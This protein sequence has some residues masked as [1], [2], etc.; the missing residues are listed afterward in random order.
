MSASPPT[1]PAE[2]V[3]ARARRWLDTYGLPS[4]RDEAWR[5]APVRDIASRLAG[6][7]AAPAAAVDP[8]TVV[9]LAGR[10]GPTG[11]V[12]VNGALDRTLSDLTRL[13][14]G[15]RLTTVGPD[16][17]DSTALGDPTDGFDAL[18]LASAP[19]IVYLTVDDGLESTD[20]VHVV[21]VSVPS[22]PGIL[23]NPRVVVDV[24]SDARFELV[25]SYV[26]V[27]GGA[28]TNAATEL[29]L[30]VGAEVTGTRVQ[31]EAPD[32]V[33]V[34]RLDVTQQKGSRL[35]LGAFSRG[36][37]VGRFWANALLRGDDAVVDLHGLS[38]PMP[39]HRHDTMVSVHHAGDRGASDQQFRNVVGARAR[40]SFSGHVVIRPGV[41]GSDAHQ[42]SDSLLLSPDARADSRP[43]LEI[44]AD[45]VRCD[46][47]STTGR[48]DDDAL[49]YLRSRGIPEPVARR[50]LVEAF[51]GALTE[52][53]RPVSLRRAIDRWLDPEATA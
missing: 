43:W 3:A 52:R 34:G 29:R 14:A 21:H 19:E 45:D 40:S 35:T 12:L 6:A 20:P 7:E 22:S 13:H 53:L 49:F 25:E 18:S 33:H 42:R 2:L 30:G 48:L 32:A 46:H 9:E 10:H 8:A 50:M 44:F 51:A 24:G 31:V 41:V 39:G 28:L 5:Y 37:A 26:G 23:S 4:E 11:I 16:G 1:G 15:I 17:F 36:G 38:V 47:G 27:A